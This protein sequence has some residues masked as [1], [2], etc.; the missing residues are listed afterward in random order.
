M[1]K[2][3]FA[4]AVLTVFTGPGYGQDSP[5]IQW[6]L[7]NPFRF[8]SNAAYMD[9]IRDVY[10]SLAVKN[11]PNLERALQD[12]ADK[13]TDARRAGAVNCAKPTPKEREKCFA[14]YSGWFARLAV[15]NYSATCWDADK[16]QF[17]KIGVCRGYV[18]PASH[19]VRVWITNQ[20]A[21]G[22]VAEWRR[23]GA[24]FTPE[25]CPPKFQRD[26]CREF[27]VPYDP[28][29][30]TTVALS[31]GFSDG[32]VLTVPIEVEDR[33]V[34][35]L[36][37]SFASGEGNPDI[38]ARFTRG[39]TDKDKFLK[40]ESVLVPQKDK[41]SDA[42][43]LDRRCHR[44][45]YS[46]QFK[47]ALQMALADPKKAVTYVSFSC[48]GAS[49]DNVIGTS[50]L[51][52][53]KLGLVG[54]QLKALRKALGKEMREIDY[55]L[56][57]AGGNDANF[58]PFVAYVMLREKFAGLVGKKPDANTAEKIKKVLVGGEGQR[59]NYLKL[60]DALFNAETGIKI[61]NCGIGKPCPRIVL[62]AYPDILT[63]EKMAPCEAN[64]GEFDLAFGVDPGRKDRLVA[65]TA[66]VFNT[67][68]DLQKNLLPPE[69]G[70]KVVTDHVDAFKGHGFCARDSTSNS[71]GEKFIMPTSKDKVWDSFDPWE[72]RSY[73]SR[74]RWV[75][76]PVDSKMTTDQSHSFFGI[77]VD[78]LQE[79]DR[80]NVM[81]PTAEG[82]ALTAQANFN[83]IGN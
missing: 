22:Q 71:I 81:H 33:L 26:N 2:V 58:A 55:L 47:T 56:L 74:R 37:D 75:R 59:G 73:V 1:K 53:E 9:Q 8:I 70:W 10:D 54:P 68:Q 51:A 35:G 49:I 5:A 42:E 72:Y 16:Q 31:A 27:D 34:V 41:G 69:L 82:L 11:G 52:M 20:H 15:N 30:K 46:Y 28:E 65:V 12:A 6:E 77:P 63:D 44:S 50:K 79:D 80:S 38:P 67:I 83:A 13:E 17:R 61:K 21:A 36:G 78:F 18:S 32:T 48:S 57:S 24:L 3:L 14:P 66:A 29:K 25:S 39:E 62:T 40:E 43:W 4:L 19:R 60:H 76:L 45:M 64:R 7:V 23:D